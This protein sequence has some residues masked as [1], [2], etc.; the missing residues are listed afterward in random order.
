MSEA[1]ARL[2]FEDIFEFYLGEIVMSASEVTV[3]EIRERG[4]ALGM[5]PGEYWETVVYPALSASSSTE[6]GDV[7][8]TSHNLWR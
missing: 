5:T 6:P 3:T 1:T 8:K 7:P 2:L 4:N